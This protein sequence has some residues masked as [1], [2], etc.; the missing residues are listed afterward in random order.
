MRHWSSSAFVVVLS[1]FSGFG[2]SAQEPNAPI[3]VEILA[4][5]DF[6]GHLRPPPGGIRISDPTDR[7]KKITVSAGGSEHMATLVKN[8]RAQHKNTVFVA[9]GRRA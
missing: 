7:T 6:H 8:L 3:D 9:A 1:V 4:I 5:N 2:S